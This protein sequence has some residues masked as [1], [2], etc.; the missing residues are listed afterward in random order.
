MNLTNKQGF[1]IVIEN[2]NFPIG[3]DLVDIYKDLKQE[4]TK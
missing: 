3:T 4:S 1:K 2:I